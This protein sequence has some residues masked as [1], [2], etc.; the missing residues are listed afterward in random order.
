MPYINEAIKRL[1]ELG[2]KG[3]S[4]PLE[5]LLSCGRG[6]L[7][8]LNYLYFQ[9]GTV[10]PTELSNALGSTTARISSILKVLEKKGEIIREIDPA[11]RSRIWVSLTDGG[12][13]RA[14]KVINAL[15]ETMSAVLREMGEKD[16]AEFLRLSNRFLDILQK[17]PIDE[18]F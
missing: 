17:Y 18:K 16:T 3:V 7:F 1:R 5:T 10:T 4:S 8:V 15:D 12:R 6:E 13:G 11:N 9:N 2:L 14:R